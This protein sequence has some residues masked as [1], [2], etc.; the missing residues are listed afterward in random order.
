MGKSYVIR[1]K[2]RGYYCGLK[3]AF[4]GRHLDHEDPNY[5]HLIP[6]P[7]REKWGHMSKFWGQSETQKLIFKR[8]ASDIPKEFIF[9]TKKDAN[10]FLK[11]KI[12]I[13]RSLRICFW[14]GGRQYLDF[15]ICDD[16]WK[17]LQSTVD[18]M[19]VVE[20]EGQDFPKRVLKSKMSFMSK[21][22]LKLRDVDPNETIFCGNCGTNLL[23]GEKYSIA[24]SGKICIHCLADFM[25][26]VEKVYGEIPK[27]NKDAYL[28][29]RMLD[30]L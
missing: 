7:T 17:K 9:G 23:E 27:E 3:R 30:A 15:D 2:G 13:S 5:G 24:Y 26:E 12:Q 20:K 6:E 18:K 19:E 4:T 14:H 10:E 1:V 11:S 25:K 29:A 21:D 28:N 22:A 16:D 8:N